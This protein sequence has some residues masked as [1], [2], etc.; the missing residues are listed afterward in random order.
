MQYAQI[1]NGE[2]FQVGQLPTTWQMKDG[3]QVSGFHL[4]EV[5]AHRQEG[6]FPLEVIRPEY[7]EATQYLTHDGYKVLD[8]KVIRKYR[9]ENIP[10]REPDEMEV[11]K[12]RLNATELALIELMMEG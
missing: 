2:L 12:E 7:D 10:E 1:K 11:L 8:D 4:L 3:S 9:V 6:W 5:E